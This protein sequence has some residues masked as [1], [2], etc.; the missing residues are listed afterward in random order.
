M[1]WSKPFIVYRVSESGQLEEVYHAEDIRQAKYWLTYIAQ[2][3][4]VLT[5]TPVHPRHSGESPSPEYWS[6]KEASGKPSRD[7]AGWRSQVAET[8]FE[9]FPTE[10]IKEAVE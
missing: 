2:P 8:N 9:S 1:E 4:D 7:E 3:G 6:H 10:Q 5:K